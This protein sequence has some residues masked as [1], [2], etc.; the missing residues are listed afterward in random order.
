M[1]RGD[2]VLYQ[3]SLDLKRKAEEKL[4]LEGPTVVQR[5][6]STPPQRKKSTES[7]FEDEESR[8]DE[9]LKKAASKLPKKR[10]FDFDLSSLPVPYSNTADPM[11]AV[12]LRDWKG[13]RVLVRINEFYVPAVIKDAA[14]DRDVIVQLDSSQGQL[15]RVKDVFDP[16]RLDV[17]SDQI[18]SAGQ[19]SPGMHVCVRV[20][21]VYAEG[22]VS[23]IRSRPTVQYHVRFPRHLGSAMTA[24]AVWVPRAGLRLRQPP[25]WEEMEPTSSAGYVGGREPVQM[26]SPLLREE[27]L[28]AVPPPQPPPGLMQSHG[29]SVITEGSVH[30]A[31]AAARPVVYDVDRCA[32]EALTAQRIRKLT[33]G[34]S[35]LVNADDDSSDDDLKTGR[36]EFD[37]NPSPSSRPSFCREGNDLTPRSRLATCSSAEMR[38]LTPRSPAS[39]TQQQQQKYK[40]GDIVSTPNGIRKKFNGKQWR[41]LCSKEGCTKESQRRGYCSRHLSLKGR[42]SGT[43]KPGSS[44]ST[45]QQH[46]F[47]AGGR[48]SGGGWEDSSRESDTSPRGSRVQGRFDL[49]E[50]EAAN[51]LVSLGNSRSATPSSTSPPGCPELFAP[52]RHPSSSSVWPPEPVTVISPDS[53]FHPTVVV[54]RPRVVK[55]SEP[56]SVIQHS[57][58]DGLGVQKA[59]GEQQ[60]AAQ[61]VLLQQALQG[62]GSRASLGSETKLYSAIQVTP[63]KERGSLAHDGVNGQVAPATV[64]LQTPQQQHPSPAHLLPVMPVVVTNGEPMKEELSLDVGAGGEF[65]L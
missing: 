54:H 25:W 11:P 31:L 57:L 20:N 63:P 17:I 18:P 64:V 2:L 56:V 23:D 27:S 9:D 34:S 22:V 1:E 46:L 52:I 26:L 6:D 8:L 12:D 61:M 50:T 36:I 30:R 55:T 60:T 10:K 29:V 49:E 3:G 16:T 33:L 38:V 47:Q 59:V 21:D 42:A 19:V 51:M 41:R 28:V 32:N 14:S 7:G 44:S 65:T 24:D 40:K 62:S 45:G 43:R 5:L 37:A 4:L 39:S 48:P 35:P 58:A 53:K 15:F 13:H